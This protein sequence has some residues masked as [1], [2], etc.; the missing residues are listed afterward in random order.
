MSADNLG[1]D[2][3]VEGLEAAGAQEEPI[4]GNSDRVLIEM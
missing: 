3:I 2:Y 1:I 4:Y